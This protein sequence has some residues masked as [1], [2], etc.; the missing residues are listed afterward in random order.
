M[1]ND[2]GDIPFATPVRSN[3]VCGEG[4]FVEANNWPGASARLDGEHVEAAGG[5]INAAHACELVRHA[6][7]VAALVLIYGFFWARLAGFFRR[8]RFYFD[9]G[10]GAAV[11]ADH[12]NFAFDSGR[13]V[14]ARDERVAVAT[15]IPVGV[16]FAADSG[17]AGA[18]FGGGIGRG[19]IGQAVAGGEVYVSEH[20]AREHG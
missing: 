19:R 1:W 2:A 20:Q 6:L 11:V 17:A 8:A 10:E 9:E 15:E 7:Q 5:H 13:G 12:I 18:I 4:A 3:E 16:G 14:V